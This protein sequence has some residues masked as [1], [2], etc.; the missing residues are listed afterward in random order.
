[1][2]IGSFGLGSLMASRMAPLSLISTCALVA[3]ALVG[4][5]VGQAQTAA[6]TPS[7]CAPTFSVNGNQQSVAVSEGQSEKANPDY[8]QIGDRIDLK[9]N[10]LAALFGRSRLPGEH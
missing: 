3:L 1:M 9:F 8:Y 7:D 4:Q 10:N 2:A 5:G 6:K